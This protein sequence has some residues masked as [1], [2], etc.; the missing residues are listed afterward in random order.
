MADERRRDERYR[1]PDFGKQFDV[2]FVER[3]S[4]LASIVSAFEHLRRHGI[5][6]VQGGAGIGKTWLL[7]KAAETLRRRFPRMFFARGSELA[8]QDHS[9]SMLRTMGPF[10]QPLLIVDGADEAPAAVVEFLR[11]F[12]TRRD[13]F[14]LAASRR[15]EASERLATVIDRESFGSIRVEVLDFELTQTADLSRRILGVRP[16]RLEVEQLHERFQGNPALMAA[17]LHAIRS[18][19]ASWAEALGPG[20]PIETTGLFGP[21]GHPL[22]TRSREYQTIATD[23][24]GVSLEVLHKLARRPEDLH[25][26]SPRLFEEVMTEIFRRKG[27]EV[28]LTPA[29]KDGGKD[30]YA[31][32]KESGVTFLTLV[33]CKHYAPDHK[34]GVELVRSLYGVV[35]EEKASA[36]ILATTSSF[37][38]GAHKFQ[39]KVQFRIGLQD[40]VGLQNL[41]KEVTQN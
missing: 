16:K 4:E 7:I 37:T 34:V 1:V 32:R 13:V 3:R 12:Q 6:F 40:F 21:D 5:A 23:V 14:V 20:A 41:L 19:S 9:A 36:G 30:I 17:A 33:E 25:L 18:N 8:N 38:A 2:E 31:V 11:R 29:S 35:E 39:R 22:S 28:T 15:W 27:Y 10:K 26:L 24:R